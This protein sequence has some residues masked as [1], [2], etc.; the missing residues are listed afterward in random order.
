MVYK[1]DAIHLY[2]WGFVRK[3]NPRF[4]ALNVNHAANSS[5]NYHWER[6]QACTLKQLHEKTPRLL[7]EDDTSRKRG[8]QKQEKKKKCLE[9]YTT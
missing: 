1:A 8:Q 5:V 4:M 9:G 2:S 3:K 6:K 7:A